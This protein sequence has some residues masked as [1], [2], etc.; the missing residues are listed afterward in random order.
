M[1]DACFS[2]CLQEELDLTA[3]NKAA[4]LS[5]PS[6]K[7]WQIY[8][9]RK[10]V[11]ASGSCDMTSNFVRKKG[12]IDHMYGL[13]YTSVFSVDRL[14]H[15]ARV[16]NW[17]TAVSGFIRQFDYDISEIKNFPTSDAECHIKQ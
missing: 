16:G 17:P 10:K 7:K 9:S 14:Q 2:V 4:M 8:C 5:L 3:P 6:E 15:I 11:S 1:F 12:L 13:I